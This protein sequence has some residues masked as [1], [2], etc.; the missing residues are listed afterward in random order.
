MTARCASATNPVA[1]GTASVIPPTKTQAA[2]SDETLAMPTSVRPTSLNLPRL[3]RSRGLV[4]AFTQ[5]TSVVAPMT[6]QI[7][8]GHAEPRHD[9]VEEVSLSRLQLDERGPHV[10]SYVPGGW[11]SDSSQGM[12]WVRS[13]AIPI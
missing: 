2:V 1:P 12:A 11:M 5:M 7:S 4:T 6:T 13:G 8:N 10:L 9:A 3:V